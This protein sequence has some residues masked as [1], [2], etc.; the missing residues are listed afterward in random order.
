MAKA[1]FVGI[2][3]YEHVTGCQNLAP[4]PCVYAKSM[5]TALTDIQGVFEKRE[6]LLFTDKDPC[7]VPGVTVAK[8]TKENVTKALRDMVSAAKKGDVLLF[9]YCGHGANEK[10]NSRG[11]LKTLRSDLSHPSVIYSDELESIFKSLDPSVS[12]TF[13]IHACFG[14][15]MFSYHPQQ[16]KGIALVSVGPDIPS[17]VSTEPDTTNFTICIRDNVIKKLPKGKPS[18]K[19]WPTCQEVEDEVKTIIVEGKT[20]DEKSFKGHAELYHAPEVNPAKRKFLQ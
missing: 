10:Q 13:L 20:P 2:N 4:V 15:A 17:V 7:E 11:A 1:I 16:M 18:D 6:C 9:Y 5:L 12:M 3:Y 14:G 19:S 8:P